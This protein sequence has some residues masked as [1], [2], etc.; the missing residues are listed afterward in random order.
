MMIAAVTQSYLQPYKN[1]MI[2]FHEMIL[3]CNY[4]ILWILLLFDGGELTNV[5]VLNV[6]VGLSFLQ[7]IIVI[8]Y[9]IYFYNV[10]HCCPGMQDIA[11]A[12]WIKVK[13][14]CWCCR[15]SG[16]RIHIYSDTTELRIP[17]VSYNLSEFREPLLDVD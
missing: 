15:Q 11:R 13:R 8:L 6:L 7:L 4:V 5:I 1:K 10:V 2:N 3:F 16:R 9:H 17:Q 12:A 14:S